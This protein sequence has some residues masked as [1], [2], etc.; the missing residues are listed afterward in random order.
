MNVI[1]PLIPPQIGNEQSR[2]PYIYMNF[3][4]VDIGIKFCL[5]YAHRNGFS[6]HKNHISRSR[7]DKSII[8][9]EFVCSKEGFRS[10]KSLESNKQLYET[11]KGCKVMLYFSKKEEGK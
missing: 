1:V 11:I 6:V 4:R 2:E 5:D 3:Q 9:Q 7:K 10:K 8:G